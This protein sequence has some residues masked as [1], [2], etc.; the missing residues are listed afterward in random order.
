MNL[1][2]KT[3]HIHS[4]RVKPY[5]KSQPV[6][7]DGKGSAVVTLVANNFEKIV[8]DEAKDVLIEFYAPW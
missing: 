5:V 2:S 4:G 3:L 7:K 8:N 1:C 6:P